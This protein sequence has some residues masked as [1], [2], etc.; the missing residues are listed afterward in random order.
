MKQIWLPRS[1]IEQWV[2]EPF[3]EKTIIDTVVR[4]NIQMRYHLAR[5]VGVIYQDE[6]KRTMYGNERVPVMYD[7]KNG[8]KSNV[9]LELTF[10]KD[11]SK[12]MSFK[13][14]LLS[15][16]TFTEKEYDLYNEIS[17]DDNNLELIDRKCRHIWNARNYKYKPGDREWI[18]QKRFDRALR[19][20]DLSEYPNITQFRAQK[21]CDRN[22]LQ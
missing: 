12:K 13:L 5:V 10:K 20:N 3:F 19:L 17:F 8:K 9:R 7:L 4:I 18:V 14:P 21:I 22:N 11:Q 6:E 1:K 2:D 16:Q 15:N